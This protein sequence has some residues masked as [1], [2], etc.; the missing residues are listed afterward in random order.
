MTITKDKKTELVQ[1]FAQKKGDTEWNHR[2]SI[3]RRPAPLRN[4]A[5][6][7]SPK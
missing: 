5:R 6:G 1:K 2:R 7:A 3:I 4:H